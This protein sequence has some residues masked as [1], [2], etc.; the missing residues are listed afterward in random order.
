MAHSQEELAANALRFRGSLDAYD[1]CRP[2]PPDVFCRMVMQY[3]SI[4]SPQL[5]VDL[6]CGTG[7]STR[8]W[9]ARARQVIGIEPSAEMLKVAQA[10]TSA[11]NTTFKNAFSHETGL[12]DGSVD[13]VTCCQSLHWMDPDRTIAE[14]ARILRPGGVWAVADYDLPLIQVE[15]NAAVQACLAKARALTAEHKLNREQK[16]WPDQ[17]PE[18]IEGSGRFASVLVCG[19]QAIDTGNSD[20]LMGLV[21]SLGAVSAP[22]KHCGPAAL[23]LDTLQKTAEQILDSQPL[24]WFWSYRVILAVK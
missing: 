4:A 21:Q 14:V 5:V 2:A 3:A 6:G 10:K 23:G 20:R 1:S 19:M 22:L 18:R 8:I 9:S 7:L 16:Q 13:I 17:H 12:A 24:E 15:L 11:P